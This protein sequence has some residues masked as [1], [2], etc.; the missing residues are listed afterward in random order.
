M[1]TRPNITD[2]GNQLRRLMPKAIGAHMEDAKHAFVIVNGHHVE[3]IPSEV[4]I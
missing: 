3:A 4:T 2:T 1:A